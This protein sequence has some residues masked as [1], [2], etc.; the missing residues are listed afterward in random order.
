M[1]KQVVQT[2]VTEL[3]A[4]GAKMRDE[5]AKT[6]K[7]TQTW[8]QRM[9]KI[10]Q[11]IALGGLAGGATIATGLAVLTK[12][13]IDVADAFDEQS[14]RV[15]IAA[16]DL[17]A[18][19]YQARFA[20]ISS[21]ELNTALL[22][23]NKTTADAYQGVGKGAD[24][25]E[26][27]GISITDA[28]GQIKSNTVLLGEVADAFAD[29]EDG[30]IKTS[31]AMDL[32]GKSVG[33][34]LV[35]ML[36]G[37]T[38][39]MRIFREEAERLGLVVKDDT[40]AAAGQFNDNLDK[41]S[42][43][44]DGFG[45]VLAEKALPALVKVTDYLADQKTQDGFAK[46]TTNVIGIGEA[47]YEAAIR[48]LPLGRA[49]SF[50]GNLDLDVDWFD[51]DEIDAQEK[52]LGRLIE[53]AKMLYGEDYLSNDR[54]KYDPIS[55][56]IAKQT[57]DLERARKLLEMENKKAEVPKEKTKGETLVTGASAANF[58][59][60]ERDMQRKMAA[61]MEKE[62]REQ[63][64]ADKEVAI[65]R[66]KFMRIHEE[67]LSADDKLVELEN[68]RHERAKAEL[69]ADL[70]AIRESTTIT[71][72]EKI[73]L[74]GEFQTAREDQEAAHQARLKDIKEQ[75]HQEDLQRQMAQ[76]DGYENLFG[77]LGDIFD[78]FGARQSKAR[79]L[80][81]IAEKSAAI[82]SATIS[83]NEGIAN[84]ARLGFPQNVGAI[85]ATVGATAGLIANIEE[86]G[87]AHGGLENVP[88]EATYRLDKG[89]RV[90]SPKQ[91]RDLTQFLRAPSG[92]GVTKIEVINQIP[93]VQMEASAEQE[94]ETMRLILTAVDNKLRQD[95]SNGRGVWREA[96][97]R[98]GLTVRGSI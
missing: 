76:L 42:G 94:G 91:N 53:R 60:I 59:E 5:M 52:S 87:I 77:S 49:L 81:L 8:G 97:E 78:T 15:N 84:S 22:K 68:Y 13:A 56:E 80:L 73:K 47:A 96:K 79:K 63:E 26:A 20:G 37:G 21:E 51:K 92:S 66:D 44:I 17:S 40:A 50:I 4:D 19:A 98:F 6:L 31:M 88:K 48:I 95:L 72:S 83:I 45:N 38:E 74:E 28:S 3:T 71:A 41:L 7:D 57:M 69:E 46:T 61:D 30:P 90:L 25:Y 54:F 24:V 23:F 29:L 34:K 75:A 55:D 70:A 33:A 32:F 39:E 10:T 86:V 82:K 2:L 16:S 27:L 43:A 35:P 11:N 65:H 12:S 89:E 9:G 58:E 36:N 85:A 93:G 67:R 64:L 1:A 14:Q 62:K 18:Y